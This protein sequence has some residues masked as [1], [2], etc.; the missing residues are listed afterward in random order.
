MQRFLKAIASQRDALL[1]SMNPDVRASVQADLDRLKLNSAADEQMLFGQIV[2]IADV[3]HDAFERYL[4]KYQ[5]DLDRIDRHANAQRIEM[6]RRQ[7]R[8]LKIALSNRS[9]PMPDDAVMNLI[10]FC[11]A[12]ISAIASITSDTLYN[13]KSSRTRLEKLGIVFAA[14]LGLSFIMYF[15]WVVAGG[16]DMKTG[17]PRTPAINT[18]AGN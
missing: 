3:L 17:H 13:E 2:I 1:R 11:R 15:G 10:Q 18:K 7:L 12:A 4:A 8:D 9:Q 14:I 6:F 5:N 16:I